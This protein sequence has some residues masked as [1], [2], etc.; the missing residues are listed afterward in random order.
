MSN[1]RIL[2]L[3]IARIANAVPCHSLLKNVEI[4]VL[5]CQKCKQC[6]NGLKSLGLLI[7]IVMV[8]VMFMVMVMVMPV[9]TQ[10]GM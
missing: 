2:N 8:M 3:N 4:V 5:N 9:S 10:K 7:V 6:H 1:S